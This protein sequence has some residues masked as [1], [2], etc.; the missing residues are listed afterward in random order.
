MI[1]KQKN[2][3]KSGVWMML[4]KEECEK[5]LSDMK[6]IHNDISKYFYGT[7]RF[8]ECMD[9][10]GQLINEHFDNPPLKVEDIKPNM[11]VWDNKFKEYFYVSPSFK[12]PTDW[13]RTYYTQSGWTDVSGN[14]YTQ[15]HFNAVYFE[16]NRFY[17]REVR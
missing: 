6:S 13:V 3:G 17:K 2:N 10:L 9:I 8:N 11:R 1:G 7:K 5:A 15:H 16:E 14:E 4:D 12:K